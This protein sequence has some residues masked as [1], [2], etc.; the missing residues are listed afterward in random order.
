MSKLSQSELMAG[1]VD[2]VS[3]E[4]AKVLRHEP[5]VTNGFFWHHWEKKSKIKTETSIKKGK[6]NGR[7]ESFY[8]LQ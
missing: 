1:N 2:W 4:I 6:K 7:E 3:P 8:N 5:R